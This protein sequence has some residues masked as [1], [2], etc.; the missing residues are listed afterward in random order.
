[1][2]ISSQLTLKDGKRSDQL[3]QP[4]EL[5]AALA[6]V[7]AALN[8]LK[9]RHYVGGSVAS[10]FHGAV[11]STMDVD[12]V[13]ELND[14]NVEAFF[15]RLS[16]DYYASE[17]AIREAVKNH[18]SFN[19]IHLPT[20]FK[21]DVFVS[22]DRPFDRDCMVRCKLESLSDRLQVPIATPEDSIIAKLEWYRA[23][24]EV[25]E[26][27]WDD[28]TRLMQLLGEQAD[29]EYLKNAANSVGVSDLLER[30]TK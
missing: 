8:Q 27:Q 6:P 19:L 26:R 20:S 14:G 13:C 9:V 18:S 21:V 17:P 25:S 22:R 11:R 29:R 1:M 16:T 5:V 24:N 2:D 7:V 4:E 10:S 23:G 30:L 15:H 28:V 12:I 3:S